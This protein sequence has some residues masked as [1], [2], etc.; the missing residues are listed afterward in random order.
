VLFRSIRKVEK[1]LDDLYD[2]YHTELE[3]V[4][5]ERKKILAEAK[6]EAQNMLRNSNAAIERT[7]KEIREAQAEK[8]KTKLARESL[9]KVKAEFEKNTYIADKF[10]KK[11][12]EIL[13]AGKNLAKYS[14]D[15]QQAQVNKKKT[16]K[17]IELK[18]GDV[19]NLKGFS[20]SGEIVKLEGKHATVAFGNM[21]SSI[22]I[23]K[24]QLSESQEKPK[25]GAGVKVDQAI[26]SRKLN[27]KSDL[28]LRGQ[29]ADDAL[30]AVQQFLDEAI[31]AGNRQLTILHGKGNGILRQLIREYLSTLSFVK[32]YSDAHADRGGAGITQ[33]VLDY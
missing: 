27:F 26:T 29:R 12:N 25:A 11:K 2:K 15:L 32:S 20:T 18:I 3:D 24:I 16:E 19:V 7:I 10:D 28:D 4:Q 1:T 5:K 14:P 21:L 8:D 9:E 23:D 22:E 30:M 6:A 13:N 17:K 33:V 31:M